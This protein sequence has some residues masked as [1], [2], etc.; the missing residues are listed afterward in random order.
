MITSEYV[1]NDATHQTL[2][3][4]LSS[5]FKSRNA[6]ISSFLKRL[7]SKLTLVRICLVYS[8][9]VLGL[10]FGYTNIHRTECAVKKK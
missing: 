7:L 4:N 10:V 2:S 1:A 3:N 6:L 5:F 8:N 9:I